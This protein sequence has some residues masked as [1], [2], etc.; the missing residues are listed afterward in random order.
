MAVT[1]FSTARVREIP[2]GVQFFV[3][4]VLTQA[5]KYFALM[6]PPGTTSTSLRSVVLIAACFLP[7]VIARV[8]WLMPLMPGILLRDNARLELHD[9]GL[10][11]HFDGVKRPLFVEWPDLEAIHREGHGV[12]LH[13]RNR[14][15]LTEA[16][17]K[18]QAEFWRGRIAKPIRL[19]HVD[20]LAPADPAR[21]ALR[22]AAAAGVAV[23]GFDTGPAR[24]R[25]V[26]V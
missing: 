5:L 17:P 12:T 6:A 13:V 15:N 23:S 16:M 25:P 20:A 19:I 24:A 9:G 18:Y 14:A 4:F 7:F 1:S 3:F 11:Y 8:P 26:P 21:R 22:N 2:L 10:I